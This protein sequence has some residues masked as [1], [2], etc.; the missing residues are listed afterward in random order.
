MNI[1][2]QIT[3]LQF[4]SH[5][6][7]CILY[8]SISAQKRALSEKHA[9]STFCHNILKDRRCLPFDSTDPTPYSADFPS[10]LYLDSAELNMF[11][12]LGSF[13]KV[14]KSV[15]NVGVTDDFLLSLGVRKSVSIDFLFENLHTLNYTD[16]PKPLVDYLRSATLTKADIQMLK[17]SQY[18][19]AENDRS[20]MFA[21]GK[22]TLKLVSLFMF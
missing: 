6:C 4:R 22:L 3:C 19:P 1:S 8:C 18:L 10:N 14:S 15:H 16:D 17:N 21:P 13:Y 2:N 12:N 20:R 5:N 9:F 7:A 11:G